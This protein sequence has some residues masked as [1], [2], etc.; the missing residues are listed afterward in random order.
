MGFNIKLQVWATHN[1]IRYDMLWIYSW[2]VQIFSKCNRLC[3][4]F[5][6]SV[7]YGTVIANV[8]AGQIIAP[9]VNLGTIWI[10]TTCA[11]VGSIQIKGL[12]GGLIGI[13]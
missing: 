8:A 7:T 10:L 5:Q 4:S 12:F 1:V 3:I 2:N 9:D 11:E 6:R 13:S